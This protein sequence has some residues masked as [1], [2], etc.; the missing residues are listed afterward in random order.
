MDLSAPRTVVDGLVGFAVAETGL[1]PVVAR[2]LV[3]ELIVLRNICCPLTKQLKHGEMPVLTTHVRASLSE[4]PATRF[5]RHAPAI[6]T[7]WT[8]E[9]LRQRPRN[10]PEC[11]T[12]L[13]RRIVRA[14][15]R[16]I[17]K[18]DF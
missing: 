11:L 9:E 4:E 6:I 5:R 13:K 3:E 2:Q 17:G 7:F 14:A 15:L 18:T 16:H 12:Q 10:V 1:G 8:P